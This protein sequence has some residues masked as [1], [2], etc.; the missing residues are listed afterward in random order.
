MGFL[1]VFV[2]LTS[3]SL[4]AYFIY[5]TQHIYWQRKKYSHIPGPPADGIL[6]FYFGNT[7][8]VYST[9]K[10]TSLFCELWKEW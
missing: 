9:V 2:A 8:K 5:I 6:G 1:E 3:G 7:Y 10:N 4:F